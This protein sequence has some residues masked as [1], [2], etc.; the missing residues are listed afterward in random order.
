MVGGTKERK[1]WRSRS[2]LGPGLSCT[3]VFVFYPEA[4]SEPANK[5]PK[6]II[7]GKTRFRYYRYRGSIMYGQDTALRREP[8]DVCSDN[9]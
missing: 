9:L 2:W 8:W 7:T 5:K 1:D 6:S 3:S 4:L